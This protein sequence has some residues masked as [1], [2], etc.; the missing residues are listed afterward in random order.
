MKY[1]VIDE[2]CCEEYIFDDL[3]KAK[4]KAFSIQ[5]VVID[6]ETSEILIDYSEF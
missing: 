5:G 3:K 4:S 2:M 6:T 1:K